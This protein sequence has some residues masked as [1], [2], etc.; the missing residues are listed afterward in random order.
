MS[1]KGR[2][3]EQRR[4]GETVLHQIQKVRLLKRPLVE[5]EAISMI[6]EELT[7]H[8][9]VFYEWQRKFFKNVVKAFESEEKQES[10]QLRDEVEALEGWCDPI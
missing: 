6:C 3:D 10:K 5:R 9:T 4:R 7:P 2:T 8:P 1:K